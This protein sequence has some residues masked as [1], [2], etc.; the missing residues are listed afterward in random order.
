MNT[1]IDLYSGIGGWTLGMKLSGIQDIASYEWWNE[2]NVTHNFNFNT[3][4]KEINIRKINVSELHFNQKIDFVVGSPPCTQFSFANR[5]G[6]GD[7]QD[8]LID[9]YKFLEIVEHVKPKYWAMENVP[10]VKKI[11]EQELRDGPLSRFQSLVKVNEVIDTAEFGVPQNRKRMIAGNFPLDLLLSYK[12]KIPLVTLGQVL[13]SLQQKTVIDPNYGY[14]IPKIDVTEL[15]NEAELTSHELRINRDAKSYHPI[16]NKMAFPD[17]LNR[18]SRT[19]TATCTRVSRESIILESKSG[20]RRLNV[21]ERGVIQGFPITYQFYGKTLN[22][23]FKMIGNAVPP[24]LTYYI[25]QSML[26][27]HS[28]DLILPKNVNYYHSKPQLKPYKSK[29]GP[30]VRKYPAKRKFMFAVPHLR[31]GSGVRFELSNNHKSPNIDWSF[32]FFY[33]TSKN[34]KQV[35]LDNQIRQAL[36]PMISTSKSK[37]FNQ[38]IHKIVNKYKNYSSAVLQDLWVSSDSNNEVFKFL[39]EVGTCVNKIMQESNLQT[40]DSN[41]ISIII[42]EENKKLSENKN[43]ILTGFYFLSS[44]NDKLFV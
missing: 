25:F 13:T 18:P 35:K 40:I 27:V 34:I 15:E 31:F 42:G 29:L 22:N 30:P 5:G 41:L 14:Q 23:K 12:S 6:N 17:R 37:I 21:R 32:K 9:I 28:K 16:Y 3:N 44:L 2:A 10:R 33:G 26:E 1:A 36:A 19:I 7:I 11:L 38:Y 8:G 43:S 39:D 20:F 4:H 24:L